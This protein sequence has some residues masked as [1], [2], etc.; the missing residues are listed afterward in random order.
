MHGMD[1]TSSYYL[2]NFVDTNKFIEKILELDNENLYI[3]CLNASF[4]RK[5]GKV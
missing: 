1:Y 2:E 3:Y 5:Y 4:F